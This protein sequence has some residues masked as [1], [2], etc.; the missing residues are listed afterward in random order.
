MDNPPAGGIGAGSAH[1][2]SRSFSWRCL[3]LLTGIV[4]GLVGAA[5]AAR[6]VE[7]QY[8]K[9]VW[10]CDPK[11][12]IQFVSPTEGWVGVRGMTFAR[13]KPVQAYLLG[14]ARGP[15]DLR[16][17]AGLQLPAAHQLID[18]FFLDRQRGWVVATK[19]EAGVGPIRLWRTEDGSKTWQELA[20]N[21]PPVGGK[22]KFVTP[23]VGWFLGRELWR[24]E[25]G[26]TTWRPLPLEPVESIDFTNMVFLTP[27]EG[28]VAGTG[29]IHYTADGG[30]TWTLQYDVSRTTRPWPWT[31]QFP[32]P[33][34]GWGAGGKYVVHTKDG[35]RTWR[36]V[37]V[38]HPGMGR[39]DR[40]TAVH[41]L[42]PQV[43]V[44]AG[45]HSVRETAPKGVQRRAGP[46]AF[47]Y[48]RPYLLVTFDGGRSWSYHEL[49]IPVGQWSQ[50]GWSLFGINTVDETE[51]A[52]GIVEIR[53]TPPKPK[54]QE[55]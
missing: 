52:T 49:P 43:G 31:I 38:T 44:V 35:G 33:T 26:G 19:R 22:I 20:H 2:S 9:D 1:R 15:D 54:A 50:V 6:P 21:L 55:K 45:Q 4:L 51:E 3:P 10:P 42:S 25:D 40:F 14:T 37:R 13:G 46:V 7:I 27:L 48:Y 16:P 32:T 8:H 30:E 41:F 36:P 28:W 11:Q 18:F 5:E 34:E 39:F 23:V 24:T 12:R 53:L 29:T 47:A 17:V